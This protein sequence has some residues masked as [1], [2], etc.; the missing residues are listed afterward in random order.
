ME[1]TFKSYESNS[2][3]FSQS[4]YFY[5]PTGPAQMTYIINECTPSGSN[6]RPHPT[7]NYYRREC[8]MSYSLIDVLYQWKA[9]TESDYPN[10]SKSLIVLDCGNG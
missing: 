6:P 10:N 8:Q 9:F 1:T 4:K 3:V 5:S 2:F 7:T